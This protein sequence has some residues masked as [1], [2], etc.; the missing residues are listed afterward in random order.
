ME[1]STKVAIENYVFA[2]FII[3]VLLTVGAYGV[4]MSMDSIHIG[5]DGTQCG[6]YLSGTY[7]LQGIMAIIENTRM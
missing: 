2:F 1:N 4:L 5:V 6:P 3:T 7:L